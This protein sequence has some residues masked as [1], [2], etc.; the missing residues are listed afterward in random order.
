MEKFPTGPTLPQVTSELLADMK[1]RALLVVLALPIV[2]GVLKA[3]QRGMVSLWRA[4]CAW[5]ARPPAW[6]I[7]LGSLQLHLQQA[8]TEKFEHLEAMFLQQSED[9]RKTMNSQSDEHRKA[10]ESRLQDLQQAVQQGYQK[11]TLDDSQLKQIKSLLI[12]ESSETRK[13]AITH[14]DLLEEVAKQQKVLETLQDGSLA[15]VREVLQDQQ[16]ASRAA[17]ERIGELSDK[18]I[19]LD[20]LVDALSGSLQKISNE[21]HV[22]FT[23]AEQKHEKLSSSITSDMGGLRTQV[24]NM[25]PMLR[26]CRANISEKL[27]PASSALAQEADGIRG[28]IDDLPIDNIMR[29]LGNTESEVLQ[30]KESVDQVWSWL[31]DITRNIQD[32]N[33]RVQELDDKVTERLPKLPPRKPPTQ[34]GATSTGTNTDV[35]QQPPETIRLQETIPAPLYVSTA[36]PAHSWPRR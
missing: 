26:E 28:R 14:K 8:Q 36:A 17:I 7:Q 1:V 4:F 12:Q 11:V 22:G 10:M 30:I 13:V 33:G 25:I 15:Q 35:Q 16:A 5:W 2:F 31:S 6:T 32:I 9:Y 34:T 19:A 18:L 24:N 3:V 21:C 20:R 27:V 23:R 29:Y